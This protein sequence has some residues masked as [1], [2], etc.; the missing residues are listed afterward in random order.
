MQLF[1]CFNITKEEK[2]RNLKRYYGNYGNNTAYEIAKG[3]IFIRKYELY[4]SLR[5]LGSDIN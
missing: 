1:F 5:S 3:K 4:P 2:K